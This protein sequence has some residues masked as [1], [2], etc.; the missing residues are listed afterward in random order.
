[1]PNGV[2]AVLVLMDTEFNVRA[3]IFVIAARDGGN[4]P[5][6]TGGD[7]WDVS[8]ANPDGA[9]VPFEVVNNHDGTYAVVYTANT[10][11][12]YTVKVDF[13]GTFGGCVCLRRCC[14]DLTR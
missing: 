1:M 3:Q 14:L 4:K 10:P 9:A 11:G 6:I 5:R 8:V 13:L 7:A 12:Q 2:R